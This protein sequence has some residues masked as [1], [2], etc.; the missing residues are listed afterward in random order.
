MTGEIH[1]DVAS[2]DATGWFTGRPVRSSNG[3]HAKV[4]VPAAPSTPTT[5]P[6]GPA[7]SS[8]APST[9]AVPSAPATTPASPSPAPHRSTGLPRTGAD[10]AS[11]LAALVLTSLGVTA[12][13]RHR[14]R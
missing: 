14:R 11:G 8:A 6:S 10:G 2:V 9:P 13:V 1:E 7:P 3:Y 5:T 4:T 12:A